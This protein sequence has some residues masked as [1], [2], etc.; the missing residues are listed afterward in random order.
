MRCRMADGAAE[1]G[2]VGLS[3]S[4]T[5]GEVR[6]SKSVNNAS[7]V[8]SRSRLRPTLTGWSTPVCS[9]RF[10]ATRAT[11]SKSSAAEDASR[12]ASLAVARATASAAAPERVPR[13]IRIPGQER[14]RGIVLGGDRWG[15]R[16][17]VPPIPPRPPLASP[18]LSLTLLLQKETTC[19][20][21]RLRF[22]EALL[23]GRG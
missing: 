18:I 21:R 3:A 10:R 9:S 23:A 19:V 16:S 13:S 1:L 20:F 7:H 8:H 17:S 2:N 12:A 5:G 4:P 15:D 22:S 6:A 11:T 14:R